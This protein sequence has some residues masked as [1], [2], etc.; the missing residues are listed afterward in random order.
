[1]ILSA[2]L[3]GMQATPLYIESSFSR[4]FAGL[5]LIG[6]NSEICK[7][8]K[9][10][11]RSTL[12]YI[13]VKIPAKKILLSSTPSDIKKNSAH[14]DLAFAASLYILIKESKPKIDTRKWL[15]AAELG[16]NGDL[17]PV[18][19]IISLIN[20]AILVKA[21]GIIIS[22]DNLSDIEFLLSNNKNLFNNLEIIAF[23][24]FGSLVSSLLSEKSSADYNLYKPSCDNAVKTCKKSILPNFDDMLLNNHLKKLASVIALGGHNTILYGEP[25][26]G[27]SMF[28]NRI[29]S[30]LPIMK[31]KEHMEALTIHSAFGYNLDHDLITGFPPMRSPHHSA[32]SAAISGNGYHP[33]ELAL[34][35]GGILFLD[36]ITEFRKD[37]LEILREPLE[38]G[39]L[40]ISRADKK[41]EWKSKIILIGACNNCPCG[42]YDSKIKQCRCTMQQVLQYNKKLSG[43][44]L[45]R[46]DIHFDM[47]MINSNI[48]DLFV[49]KDVSN[50][51]QMFDNIINAFNFSKKRLEKLQISSNRDIESKDI[52]YSSGLN[53]DKFQNLI[54][55]LIPSNMSTR[56]VVRLLR[57]ART[58][59]DIEF[60]QTIEA[61]HIQQALKWQTR[62]I[63]KI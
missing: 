56:G 42:W 3:D 48:S 52:V 43:P 10:R 41:Q 9:E 54:D 27:K 14:F 49:N 18:K 21:D 46:I 47:P 53:F 30:L 57:V 17:R 33:G 50:T 59:A 25:G 61:D 15:F 55:K 40:N 63:L 26:C 44:I 60:S 51:K 29:R 36:E 19:G 62:S 20:C 1:M 32:S 24:H 6:S 28:S 45:D 31:S 37:I 22:K 4:G 8:G 58:L 2:A 13:N 11:A 39:K 5:Q 35:H 38:T 12:E 16:L 34:A 23:D 7:E